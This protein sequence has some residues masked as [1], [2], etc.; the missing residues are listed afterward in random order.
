MY[1]NCLVSLFS[2]SFAHLFKKKGSTIV[3]KGF[4]GPTMSVQQKEN[5]SGTPNGS[6]RRRNSPV[7]VFLNDPTG[8][9]IPIKEVQVPFSEHGILVDQQFRHETNDANPDLAWSRIRAKYQ[10]VF[11][12]FFGVF[13]LIL[14]GDGVVAQVVLSK[15]E[16]GSYQS[17]TWGKCHSRNTKKPIDSF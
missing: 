8:K 13:V 1:I 12:E 9:E 5:V 7:S 10:E 2:D 15:G 14:F 4:T 16:N 6:Q 17:I 3:S 11:S